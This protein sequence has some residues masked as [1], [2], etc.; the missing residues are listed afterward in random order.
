MTTENVKQL[1][2]TKQLKRL[3]ENLLSRML[4]CH[5]SEY[6]EIKKVYF[7]KK[8]ELNNRIANIAQ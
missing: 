3:T 2:E 4:N 6:A 8:K 1:R 7:E 5:I